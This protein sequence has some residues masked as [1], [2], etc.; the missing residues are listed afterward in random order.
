[1]LNIVNDIKQEI[2]NRSNDFE[3]LTKGTKEELLNI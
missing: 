3:N 2:I 1:M